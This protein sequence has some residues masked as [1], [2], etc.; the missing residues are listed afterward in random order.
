M[1]PLICF[2]RAAFFA[3]SVSLKRMGGGMLVLS[4]LM[5]P[6]G[7]RGINIII[8]DQAVSFSQLLGHLHDPWII[9]SDVR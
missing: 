2:A 8:P 6:Y 3:L 5:T 7:E 1:S 4:S 9:I